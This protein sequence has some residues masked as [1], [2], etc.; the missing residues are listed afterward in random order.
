MQLSMIYIQN[1]SNSSCVFTKMAMQH[2]N[3]NGHLKHFRKLV[4]IR[5]QG[6]ARLVMIFDENGELN[7]F[8]S[9]HAGNTQI[10]GHPDEIKQFNAGL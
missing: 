8:T 7:V 1:A 9:Y 4:L 2:F 5:S 10:A 6:D 3:L